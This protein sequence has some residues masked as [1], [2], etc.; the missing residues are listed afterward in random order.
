MRVL[1]AA[2]LTFLPVVAQGKSLADMGSDEPGVRLQM[3]RLLADE[4]GVLTDEFGLSS[5]PYSPA[6]PTNFEACIGPYLY[7]QGQQGS[8]LYDPLAPPSLAVQNSGRD[9]VR[10]FNDRSIVSHSSTQPVSPYPDD[11]SRLTRR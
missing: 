11:F 3:D 10:A 1:F 2:I 8:T 4:P 7:I 6:S 9:H 5:N